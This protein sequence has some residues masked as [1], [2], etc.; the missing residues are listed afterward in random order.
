MKSKKK[1]EMKKIFVLFIIGLN[2][3]FAHSQNNDSIIVMT[4]GDIKVPLSEFLFIAQKDDSGV[5]LLDKKSRENYIELFKTFKLKVADAL[6]LRI[7]ESLYFQNELDTYHTQLVESYISDNDGEEQA[8][9]KIY[10]QNKYLLSLNHIMFKLPEKSLPN[11]TL[12][13]FLK[14]NAVY[15]RIKAGEDIVT[16]GNALMADENS[17]AV[18]EEQENIFPIQTFKEIIEMAFSMSPGD[19]SIPI[20]TPL[21]YHIIR[22]NQK[23]ANTDRL[24][25]AHILLQ[26]PET[27]EEEDEQSLL[28]DATDIYEKIKNGEDFAEL[29]ERYSNDEGTKYGGGA[30]PS[31]GLGN[32]VL[33]FEQAAFALENIGDVS[34]PVRTRFGYHIIKLLGKSG[35]PSF[36]EMAQSIYTSMQQGDLSQELYKVFDERQK[37]KMGYIFYQD[38]Y[39]ELL[40]LCDDYF[41]TDTTFYSL[42]SQMTKPIMQMQGM[43]FPQYEFVDYI[44]LRSTSLKTYSG[45]FLNEQ[46]TLYVREIISR[47]IERNVEDDPVFISLMNEYHDGILYFEVSE[48]KVWSKPIEEQDDLEREWIN[49]LNKKYKVTINKKVLNNLKK[50]L[51]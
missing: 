18:Y 34:K 3:C 46:Y 21:G 51:K 26:V 39:N 6:S 25:V 14:A 16:V 40:K 44:R 7:Q 15:N 17:G 11:D 4:V 9:R 27:F 24:Q 19:I 28:K 49:E 50:Y 31:F 42:T 10:E 41:P 29:A 36:E 35:Y 37:E 8:M 43:D 38:A 48:T 12:E 5:N 1:K 23:I 45:D 32:M 33:Q 22:L 2:F 13:V 20:R 30:L 47:L